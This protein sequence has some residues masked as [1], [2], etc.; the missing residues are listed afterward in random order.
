MTAYFFIYRLLF[1]GLGSSLTIDG[2]VEMDAIVMEG[3]RMRAGA[4]AAV[5]EVAS[6]VSLSRKIMEQVSRL[7]K[8]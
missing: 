5:T 3:T 8:L 7:N 1:L 6:P 4:V 2:K